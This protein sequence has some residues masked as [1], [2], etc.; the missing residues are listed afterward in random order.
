MGVQNLHG[1]RFIYLQ[2]ALCD[3]FY[4]LIAA[5]VVGMHCSC[6]GGNFE[7]NVSTSYMLKCLKLEDNF[8][9]TSITTSDIV[10]YWCFYCAV[11]TS[12]LLHGGYFIEIT[13]LQASN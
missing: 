1:L 3:G 13:L 12:S 9:H 6:N 10:G 11:G 2:K 4:F 7:I 5:L 8:L